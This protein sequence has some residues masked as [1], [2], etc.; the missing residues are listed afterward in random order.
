M[1]TATTCRITVWLTFIRDADAPE[2]DPFTCGLPAN[3]QGLCDKHEADRVR[4]GGGK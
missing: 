4:L 1:V 2:T 3:D